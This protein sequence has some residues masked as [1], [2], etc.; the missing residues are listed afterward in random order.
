MWMYSC[1]FVVFYVY[2]YF[3]RP[4]QN[5]FM[6]TCVCDVVDTSKICPTHH[7]QKILYAYSSTTTKPHTHREDKQT[8][9][10]ER[11]GSCR[12]CGHNYKQATHGRHPI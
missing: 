2:E 3:V 6:C 5:K 12:S 7:P 11:P 10:K 9:V 1:G 4:P 8:L